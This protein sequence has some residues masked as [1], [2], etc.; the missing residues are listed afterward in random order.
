MATCVRDRLYHKIKM[1]SNVSCNFLLCFNVDFT[2]F[3]TTFSSVVL[4]CKIKRTMAVVLS[5]SIITSGAHKTLVLLRGNYSFLHQTCL[6][7]F[8][9]TEAELARCFPGRRVTS[10]NNTP[11]PKPPPNPSKVDKLISDQHREHSRVGRK[12]TTNF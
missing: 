2:C 3:S 6:C 11:L 9:Q 12:P 5:W 1:K 10:S 7:K 4:C 8:L